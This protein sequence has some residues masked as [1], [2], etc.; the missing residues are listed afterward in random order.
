MSD[1]KARE[2]AQ[3]DDIASS[4]CVDPIIGFTTHKMNP[5]FRHVKGRFGRL[6]DVI[7]LYT[8]DGNMEKAYEMLVSGNWSRTFLMGKP[9]QQVVAFKEHVSDKIIAG[10]SPPVD[11]YQKFDAVGKESLWA[12]VRATVEEKMLVLHVYYQSP[13]CLC[14]FMLQA[15]AN[16]CGIHYSL[17]RSL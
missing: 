13:L 16:F 2:L 7:E 11:P 8:K 17:I 4:L 3:Y 5:R 15:F 1:V 12:I 9:R 14:S 10:V 6:K